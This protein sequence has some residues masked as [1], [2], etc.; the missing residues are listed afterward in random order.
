MILFRVWG[1]GV[2]RFWESF[3]IFACIF[4]NTPVLDFP[5]SLFPISWQIHS[6]RSAASALPTPCASTM[7]CAATMRTGYV[8]L[9]WPRLT[10]YQSSTSARS[11]L[12]WVAALHRP[13]QSDQSIFNAKVCSIHLQVGGSRAV[14]KARFWSDDMKGPLGHFSRIYHHRLCHMIIHS[15]E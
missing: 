7:H 14:N 10:T 6:R 15:T 12:S 13:S 1:F 3:L 9:L 2:L 4:L 8:Y 11:Y 5:L